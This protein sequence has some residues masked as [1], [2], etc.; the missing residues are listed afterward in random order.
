MKQA[1]E[2]QA[3][4]ANKK[5]QIPDFGPKD[6]VYVIK[7][8]WKTDRP[9]DKLDYP[10]AS[11]FEILEIVGHLYHLKLPASYRVWLVFYADRLCKDPGNPLPSQVNPKPGAE[12]V[13][14]KLEWEVEKILSSCV[15]YGKLYYK[16]EWRG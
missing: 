11:P 14:S 2:Q 10:L 1:Q 9:S 7:K 4:Q 6:K 13:N 16:V 5:R 3:K 8:T 15:L 12:E